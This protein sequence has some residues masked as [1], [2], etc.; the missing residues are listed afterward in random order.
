MNCRAPPSFQAATACRGGHSRKGG[1]AK[2]FHEGSL[3]VTLDGGGFLPRP[4]SCRASRYYTRILVNGYGTG[5]AQKLQPPLT[6][7]QQPALAQCTSEPSGAQQARRASRLP[8][9]NTFYPADRRQL[10]HSTLTH[11]RT[12]REVFTEQGSGKVNNGRSGEQGERALEYCA[13]FEQ[14]VRVIVC[15][16]GAEV[17]VW[18]HLAH[19]RFERLVD[20]RLSGGHVGQSEQRE[21][22]DNRL[23]FGDRIGLLDRLGALVRSRRRVRAAHR[24]VPKA[25][26]VLTVDRFEL[27]EEDQALPGPCVSDELDA[28]LLMALPA[29]EGD[30]LRQGQQLRLDDEHLRLRHTWF[31]WGCR[32]AERA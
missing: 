11:T 24:F 13:G 3:K 5:S 16:A 26:D 29:A 12:H 10:S 1:K 28:Q 18:V 19:R 4:V 31:S 17:T 21:R 6:S 7:Q 25:E 32:L 15:G 20:G 22:G 14:H 23:L 30:A 27:R 9:E 2:H 8:N